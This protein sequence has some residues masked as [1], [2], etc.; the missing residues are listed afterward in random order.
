MDIGAIK[1]YENNPRKNKNAVA[2]VANSIRSYGFQQP[3]VI[4]KNH[5]VIVG[6]TRLLAAKQLG[7]KTVPIIVADNLTD[8]Q[9]AA[10]RIADNRTGE[11]AEWDEEL[12]ELEL[13]NLDDLYTGFDPVGLDVGGLTD[14]DDCPDIDDNTEAITQLGDVWQLGQHRLLCGDSTNSEQVS[15]LLAGQTPH[16]M[17]TDPPYGVNYDANW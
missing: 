16:L 13:Q 9:V 8:K 12:L 6:H 11:F 1:P 4:D 15:K 3:I 17:V 5:I 10:Y 2:E 14:E 7:L